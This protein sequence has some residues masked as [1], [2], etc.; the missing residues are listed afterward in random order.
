[1]DVW[2]H[3][4]IGAPG[5]AGA[6]SVS[7]ATFSVKGGGG[8][9]WKTADQF[10]YAFQPAAGDRTLTARV[11]TQQNTNVWAKSGVMI[12]ETPAAGSSYVLVMVTPGNGVN[13]QYRPATGASAVSLVK[14]TGVTAPT[15]VRLTRAGNTFTGFTSNDGASWSTL[16]SIAVTM[17]GGA[18]AGLAV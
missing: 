15:W 16:G 4:D 6:A 13:M 1:L 3:L 7:A 8:D 12:H 17:A 2:Q 9:I 14:R 18:T 11:A 10:H 5:V